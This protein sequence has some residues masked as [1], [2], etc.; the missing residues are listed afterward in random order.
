MS[1]SRAPSPPLN[2]A[3][4]LVFLTDVRKGGIKRRSFNGAVG[5]EVETPLPS[6]AMFDLVDRLVGLSAEDYLSVVTAAKLY[7]RFEE[8]NRS[9][10]GQ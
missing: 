8:G 2:P 7:R 4:T 10:R 5:T 1:G 9:R 6:D 3:K